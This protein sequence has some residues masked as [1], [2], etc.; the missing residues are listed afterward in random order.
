[1]EKDVIALK[2]IGANVVR[3][4]HTTP[5]PYFAS[6]CD[7]YGL[8]YT[9]EVPMYQPPADIVGTPAYIS[10]AKDMIGQ[11]LQYFR[12]S[13]AFLAVGTS[14]LAPEGLPE[15][16]RYH[17][18]LYEWI[19]T[20]TERPVYKVISAR[21]ATL[22]TAYTDIIVASIAND[23]LREF[24]ATVERLMS[25]VGARPLAL[26]FGKAIQPDN[27]NGYSDPLSVEA[28]AKYIFDRLKFLRT[29][30]PA[31]GAMVHTFRDYSTARAVLT[32]NIENPFIYTSGLISF[33][34]EQRLTYQV[35]KALFNEEREPVIPAGSFIQQGTVAYTVTSIIMAVLFFALINSSRR[36]REN[37]VRALLRPYNFYADI[38]DQRILSS[39]RS[40]ILA[41]ILS[42]T[43][44][45]VLSAV[46]YHLRTSTAFDYFLNMLIIS[47]TAKNWLCHII[48]QPILGI[49][50]FSLIF[51]VLFFVLS[52]VIRVASLFVKNRI[53]FS[54]AFIVTVWAALPVLLLLPFTML[55]FQIL[56]F[57]NYTG[58]ALIIFGGTSI[59]FLYRVLRG[60]AVIFD[61]WASQVY[62]IGIALILAV[63]TTVSYLYDS[64]FALFS[65]LQFFLREIY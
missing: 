47:D 37:I 14:D 17:K 38:R 4:R 56:Q 15:T 2:T 42:A 41:A 9:I 28:Q 54:D 12:I 27:H 7:K 5:H 26:H 35:T 3:F 19:R 20:M 58:M 21:S 64:G 23:N 60:T 34:G 63:L 25:M 36:F 30:Y 11:A 13:P 22:D 61:I 24:Q 45:M 48:W 65:Y 46:A 1:M 32:T 52:A 43:L 53:M 51:L 62:A 31:I 55:I 44:G 18:E 6:L 40:F 10:T 33:T 59:W 39:A 8:L 16:A 57:G 29:K 49:V 50:T